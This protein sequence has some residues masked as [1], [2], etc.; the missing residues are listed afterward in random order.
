MLLKAKQKSETQNSKW[1][2]VETSIWTDRM[3]ATLDNGVKGGKWFSLWDK[4]IYYLA[5]LH[6]R[7]K[8]GGYTPQAI[9]RVHIPYAE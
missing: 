9:K 5:R 2:W 8:E 1:D 7:L 4:V 3:L 6:Q